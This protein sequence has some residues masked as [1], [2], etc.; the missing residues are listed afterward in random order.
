[1][2]SDWEWDDDGDSDID[3]IDNTSYYHDYPEDDYT[4]EDMLRNIEEVKSGKWRS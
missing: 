3:D 1:M 2:S 4:E